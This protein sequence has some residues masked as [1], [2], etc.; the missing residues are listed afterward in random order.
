MIDQ[1]IEGDV[2]TLRLLRK[3]IGISINTIKK[4]GLIVEAGMDGVCK[5][6]TLKKGDQ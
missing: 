1:M 2:D 4:D 3:R 5:L 6:W